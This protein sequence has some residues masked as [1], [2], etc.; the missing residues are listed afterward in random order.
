MVHTPIIGSGRVVEG[1]AELV[2][3]KNDFNAH[4]EGGGFRHTANTIDIAALPHITSTNLQG[5]LS[6]LNN[7]LVGL[8]YTTIGDGV[9]SVGDFTVSDNLTV[10]DCFAL[11]FAS[12]QLSSGGC[13]LMKPGVYVFNETV[14]LPV[15]VSVLGTNGSTILSAGYGLIIG[16]KAMFVAPSVPTMII[17]KTQSTE[18][19][20]DGYSINNFS[21]LTFV[22]N[23]T[24]NY[25]VDPPIYPNLAST[26]SGAFI[27][28][29][30]SS[31]I[32][33]YNCTVIGKSKD[34]INSLTTSITSNFIKLYDN[35][36]G[37]GFSVDIQNCIIHGVQKVLSTIGTTNSANNKITIKNNK[38]WCFSKE[39]N[40]DSTIEFTPCDAEFVGNNIKYETMIYDNNI[41]AELKGYC[42]HSV[43]AANAT[44]NIIINNN[45]LNIN[46][47]NKNT[48]THIIYI[49][50]GNDQICKINN[51]CVNGVTESDWYI[52]IG[53]GINSIG[54]INGS[55]SLNL[56]SNLFPNSISAYKTGNTSN[57]G[58]QLTILLR[59]GNY[60]ID[61]TFNVLGLG[62]KLIG[63]KENGTLPKITLFNVTSP[64]SIT[65]WTV[66]VDNY[67]ILGTHLENIHFYSLNNTRIVCPIFFQ[68]NSSNIKNNLII[69]NCIFNNV[70]ILPKNLT[71]SLN[72]SSIIRSKVII[73]NCMLNNTVSNSWITIAL[74]H[75]NVD[76]TIS[77]CSTEYSFQ[78]YPVNSL[79]DDDG[80]GLPNIIITNCNFTISQMDTNIYDV[81]A[82][83][84]YA[85]ININNTI[86]DISK[87]PIS[88]NYS[89]LCALS[90]TQNIIVERSK[91]I[92]NNSKCSTLSSGGIGLC[93]SNSLEGNNK[94]HTIQINENIFTGLL[95]SIIE[96]P[97]SNNSNVCQNIIIKNNINNF[98]SNSGSFF[99]FKHTYS[100]NILID[101]LVS[102]NII[103]CTGADESQICH[104]NT[105]NTCAII[106]CY[107]NEISRANS[108]VIIENNKIQNVK[109]STTTQI[110]QSSISIHG[111]HTAKIINNT[112]CM[113]KNV[114]G[115]NGYVI[116]CQMIGTTL[117][118]NSSTYINGNFIEYNA[119]AVLNANIV[120]PIYVKNI[121]YSNIT[122]NTI[123]LSNN[124]INISNYIR[125]FSDPEY[126]NKIDGIIENNTFSNTLR[127][128]NIIQVKEVLGHDETKVN[129]SRIR[130][131]NNK[132]QK[133]K[134]DISCT[135]FKQYGFNTTSPSCTLLMKDIDIIEARSSSL[136]NNRKASRI[137]QSG[138][139]GKGDIASWS[140]L[141]SGLYYTN[142]WKGGPNTNTNASDPMIEDSS[143]GSH[144]QNQI[145]IPLS[146][147]PKD[148]EILNIDIPVYFKN[149]SSTDLTVMTSASWIFGNSVT[150]SGIT[151]YY[152][153]DTD[154]GSLWNGNINIPLSRSSSSQQ[155]LQYNRFNTT[156][157]PTT[158]A[159]NTNESWIADSS[160]KL[161]SNPDMY[162]LL[163][164]TRSINGD[165]I[166]HLLAFAIP[167]TRVTIR[168]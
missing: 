123:L 32:K 107:C 7:N 71:N 154:T 157:Q 118:I 24:T 9:N 58:D 162:I 19:N 142:H 13:I 88:V 104:Y 81:L 43:G 34:S 8:T 153:T 151:Q 33:V 15:G 131:C 115:V 85:N 17:N 16:S 148:C 117:D 12:G 27:Q 121:N 49:D 101:L 64:A 145:L 69:K 52:T 120:V 25:T 108:N 137:I 55:N 5:A 86:I 82:F 44:V 130:I 28:I 1:N 112:I 67:I 166:E 159:A 165:A 48:L 21:N 150:N 94:E 70:G 53:D 79:D 125:V 83:I 80:S 31:K 73:D 102:N 160:T 135:Q 77:N 133:A 20:S 97:I 22:D 90:A 23:Y 124:N 111:F 129:D 87:I 76:Y 155:T 57:I 6:Q 93:I 122:N 10:S 4:V 78:G 61:S 35:F 114:A 74:D 106:H 96:E 105:A 167:Y 144:Y 110:A 60:I 98:T 168:Y 46:S 45:T 30:N 51:N 65:N 146:G 37:T 119:N 136:N 95:I 59:P 3:R 143:S 161:I 89:S 128:D 140:D 92:G 134:F 164:I 14:T 50:N 18:W 63:L 152:M 2:T 11:A 127:Y 103:N 141:P 126:P 113:T 156:N 56:L 36:P 62:C 163:S 66:D 38:I 138:S 149:L 91:F 109:T 47:I 40:I 54:D 99:C 147:L 41:P 29:T 84:D 75:G 139:Y 100:N 42:F 158:P 132:N 72:P 68:D 116:D 39:T 26:T